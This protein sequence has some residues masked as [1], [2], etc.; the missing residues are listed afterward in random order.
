[1]DKI[2]GKL[3]KPEG[4]KSYKPFHSIGED[5][6]QNYMGM[7]G[8]PVEI[9]PE[10]PFDAEMVIL[11]EQAKYDPEI[12]VKIKKHLQAGNDVM[13]TSGLFRAL[14]DKGIKDIVEMVYTERKAAIDTILVSTRRIP[15]VTKATITIPQMTYMTNDSWEDISTLDY[16][17]AWPMLQQIA[18]SKGNLFVWIIPENFSHI[19]ALPDLALNRLRSILAKDIKIHIE[20]PAQ[21]ALLTYDNNSFVVQSFLDSPVTITIMTDESKSITDLRSGESLTGSNSRKNKIYGRNEEVATRYQVTIP[22]HSF[23]GFAILK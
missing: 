13:I 10:F 21:I 8:I 9:V 17:N 1:V 6:L 12:I 2:L 22:P 5:F 23:R 15:A 14:Q 3:G 4:I 19:Y 20:G 7:A 11:T 18:Y 16:G